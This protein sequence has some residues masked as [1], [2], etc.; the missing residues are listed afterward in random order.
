MKALSRICTVAVGSALLAGAGCSG[1]GTKASADTVGA[2]TVLLAEDTLSGGADTVEATDTATSDAPGGSDV[3]D[4]VTDTAVAADTVAELCGE[5]RP[6]TAEISGAIVNGDDSW[7]PAVVALDDARGLAVGA[8]TLSY[9]GQEEIICTGTLVAPQVVLTAA[10]CVMQSP[11]ST[12]PAGMFGFSVGADVASPRGSFDVSAVHAHPSYDYWG[13]DASHDVA[14]LVL[15]SSPV[16]A[17]GEAIRPLPVN[18]GDIAASGFV[19][20]IIQMVGYGATNKYG[21]EFGTEQKW[22]LEEI[23][24]L[25]S[26]DFTVDGNDLAGV[27]YGDSGGPALFELNGGAPVI[28]GVLSWGDELCTREDHFVRTDHEC[29]FISGYLPSCGAVTASG[30]CEGDVAVYCASDAVVEDD[31]AARGEVC[32]ADDSGAARCAPEVVDPCG[33]ETFAGRC[34][35]ATAVWCEDGAVEQ[36]A[37]APCDLGCGWIEALGGYDCVAQ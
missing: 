37:C 21:T 12:Y 25:S 31:C 34:D 6:L 1:G 30:S 15:E 32:A 35:G 17:L 7:D 2:D 18:C 8:V 10:H 4:A 33:G 5:A 24:S 16:T 28:V 11:Y 19:G 23:V 22:A 29:D 9:R 36:R 27:C 26:L 13:Y 3:A 14:V 20:E